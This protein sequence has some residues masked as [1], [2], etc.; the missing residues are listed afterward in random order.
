ML[1]DVR[2]ELKRFVA[3]V[4]ALEHISNLVWPEV[5]KLARQPDFCN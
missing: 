5:A 2:Q 4:F 3:H 1:S